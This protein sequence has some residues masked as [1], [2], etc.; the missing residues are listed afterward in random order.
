MARGPMLLK[1]F[2]G[3]DAL[4]ALELELQSARKRHDA[5]KASARECE[6]ILVNT[7]RVTTSNRMGL[8]GRCMA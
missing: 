6:D 7:A 3:P 4:G 8:N 5:S 2:A 1:S